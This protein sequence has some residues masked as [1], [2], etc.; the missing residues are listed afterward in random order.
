MLLLDTC[1]REMT[2]W[3]IFSGLCVGVCKIIAL[4]LCSL[5]GASLHCIGV[6]CFLHFNSLCAKTM[7][8]FCIFSADVGAKM[9][10]S[11]CTD[12]GLVADVGDLRPDVCVCVY[13]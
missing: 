1:Y 7:H 5:K 12:C 9:A 3:V 8:S 13:E 10:F 4:L 6:I 2:I 11:C